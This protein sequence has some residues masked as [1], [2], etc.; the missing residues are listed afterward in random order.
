MLV[1]HL[2]S[3]LTGIENYRNLRMAI[4]LAMRCVYPLCSHDTTADLIGV[5]V[6]LFGVTDEEI[7]R[8]LYIV[9]AGEHKL[10]IQ[11]MTMLAERIKE[12]VGWLASI[13][14]ITIVGD[15]LYASY[16]MHRYKI[17]PEKINT[18]LECPPGTA[19]QHRDIFNPVII[20][21]TSMTSADI[22]H[23]F[24]GMLLFSARG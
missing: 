15:P 17:P 12:L 21:H 8:E 10:Y 22:D 5:A 16:I 2:F 18:F 3:I 24:Y 11:C 1:A 13:E 20:L 23:M 9:E 6:G 7:P 14:T 19:F 4:L